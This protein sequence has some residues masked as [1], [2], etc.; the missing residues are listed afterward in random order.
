MYSINYRESLK[1]NQKLKKDRMIYKIRE[2]KEFLCFSCFK[3]I[4][5][6]F[7]FTEGFYIEHEVG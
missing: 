4:W 3:Q 6:N 5:Y 1:N 7:K 2:K